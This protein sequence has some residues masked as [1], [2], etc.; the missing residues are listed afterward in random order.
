MPVGRPLALVHDIAGFL[1]AG[2]GLA[3]IYKGNGGGLAGVAAF[4]RGTS[5]KLVESASKGCDRR[6]CTH[7]RKQ[8][9][10]GHQVDGWR[11][12]D[13]CSCSPRS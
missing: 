5:A 10:A 1:C 6:S 11:R 12:T 8:S 3:N 4:W 2:Q 13:R 9:R 7:L